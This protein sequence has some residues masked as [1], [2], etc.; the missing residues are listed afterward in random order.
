MEKIANSST[1]HHHLNKVGDIY[2]SESLTFEQHCDGGV[3]CGTTAKEGGGK[4]CKNTKRQISPATLRVLLGLKASKEPAV[5]A[6]T[7]AF[8]GTQ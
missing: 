6:Q 5:N 7:A 2:Q 3:V 8:T 4:D 1:S